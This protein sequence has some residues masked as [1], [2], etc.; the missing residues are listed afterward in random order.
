MVNSQKQSN[1][2]PLEWWEAPSTDVSKNRVRNLLKDVEEF[3]N[4]I[5][6]IA[7]IE[8]IRDLMGV[9]SHAQLGEDTDE[10]DEPVPMRQ[11]LAY[12]NTVHDSLEIITYLAKLGSARERLSH[13]ALRDASEKYEKV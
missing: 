6:F 11:V 13:M 5:G 9:Y 4:N 2:T 8:N 3:E 10:E 12:H 7:A 1:Q